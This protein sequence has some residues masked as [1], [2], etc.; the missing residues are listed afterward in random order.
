[1]EIAD[2]IAQLAGKLYIFA[3]IYTKK[4]TNWLRKLNY[5][6]PSI[7]SFLKSTQTLY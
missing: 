5:L 6:F 2:N 1:M 3:D 4:I 7:F